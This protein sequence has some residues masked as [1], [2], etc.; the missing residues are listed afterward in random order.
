MVG[1]AHRLQIGEDI[2]AAEAVNRLLGVADEEQYALGVGVNTV[3]NRVLQRV[4]VLEFVD[5]GGG[6]LVADGFRQAFARGSVEGVVEIA[7]QVVEELDVAPLLA[8]F[9]FRPGIRRQCV[10]QREQAGFEALREGCGVVLH[11]LAELKKRVFGRFLV[12]LGLGAQGVAA[13]FIETLRQ[14]Q[15]DFVAGAQTVQRRGPFG[16]GVR[17]IRGPA[18][19]GMVS[20]RVHHAVARLRP[21]FAHG[22][23][24]P[25]IVFL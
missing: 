16:N 10:F 2:R 11:V 12:F 7:Q 14:I 13:K 15:T 25:P 21:R 17:F 18:Q 3:E 19:G 6:E 24:G 20:E 9:Q 1:V 22:A 5:E 4:G 8:F 23:E